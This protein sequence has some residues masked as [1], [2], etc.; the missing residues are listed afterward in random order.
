MKP[1]LSVEYCGVRFKNPMMIASAS[2]SK[3][4]EYIRRCAESGAGGVIAKTFSP[5]P[6]AQK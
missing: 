3:N 2:P 1:N 4:A 6:L 5:E